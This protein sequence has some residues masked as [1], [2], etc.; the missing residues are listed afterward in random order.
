MKATIIG[1]ALFI[2]AAASPAFA[3]CAADIT[4][5]DEA[6]KTATLDEASMTKAKE[7]LDKAKAAQSANDEAGCTT[8][9][10]EVLTMLGQ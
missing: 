1:T 8:S 10:Q 5:I 4:K 2:V 6:M 7:V 3:D 9:A